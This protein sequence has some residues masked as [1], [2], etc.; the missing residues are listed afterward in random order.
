MTT[1]SDEQKFSGVKTIK[2]G[3]LLR[4]FFDCEEHEFVDN[5]DEEKTRTGSKCENVD[6]QS[7]WSYARIVSA[8][9]LDKYDADSRDAIFANLERAKDEDS[10]LTEEKR[11]EYIKE[12]QD[13]QAYRTHAKEIATEVI[14]QI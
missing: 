4:L 10:D 2:E 8:I 11:E 12:Y 6:V 1:Y 13:Y 14:N 7:P 3:S 5:F 9:I